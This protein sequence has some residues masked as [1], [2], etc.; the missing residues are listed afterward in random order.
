[1]NELE[2]LIAQ[3][4]KSQWWTVDELEKLQER[5]L[6][7]LIKHHA[8]NSSHFGM[9]L[10]A[11]GL[12]PNSVLTLAGLKR[13]KPFGKREIQATGGN[14][15]AKSIPKD[16]LPLGEAQTSGS[17]GQP[18]KLPKGRLTTLYW[19]AHV[20]R[21]HQW[22]GRDYTGKLASIR[23]G[24]ND[25][26]EADS[27]GG[28]VPML[29]GSG[30]AIAIPV[31][32][33]ITK[34]LEYLEKFQ[35][36]IIIVHAGVLTGFVSEWERK[37]FSLPELKHIKNVGETV[38]DDLRERLRAV[39]GLEIEDNYSCSEVGSIAIQ[40]PTSGLFHIMHENLIVEVIN[41]DGSPT[42]VGD[43]GRVVVTDLFNSA[44]PMIRYD[45][46]DHAEVGPECTCGRHGTTLK[47]I[48]GRDRGLFQRADG[49][50]FWPQA[51]QYKMSKFVKLLQWQ[52]VQHAIDDIEY[53]MVTDEPVAEEQKAAM[54][55]LLG[56]AMG[57]P[58]QV[59]IT[60]FEGSIPTP[61][62]K[63]EETICLIK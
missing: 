63:Y 32:T 14:F 47:R 2:Q 3:L 35:P 7:P 13:L 23:A 5:S 52:I 19:H 41:D 21:D 20:I 60:V 11:Q 50:R 61:K 54:E 58:G 28:P 29:Y 16:H 26:L 24:F 10:A 56:D 62:G 34:Q 44:A 39:S 1:M 49:T 17:T 6:V 27:W 38:H 22:Y 42:E 12:T 25:Y 59:R 48:M 18:V 31:V 51:H 36:N 43:V 45:I 9:R 40:C 30:P 46:G 4:D 57:F 15:A 33:G 55:E 37:G 53:K 8:K